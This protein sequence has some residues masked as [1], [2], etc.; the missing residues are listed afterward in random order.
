MKRLIFIILFISSPVFA[1]DISLD[2]KD[3]PVN[4]LI[5]GIVKGLLKQDYVITPEAASNEQKISLS[6]KNLDIEGVKTTLNE[7]LNS[8][9][10]SV[11]EKRGVLYIEKRSLVAPD[12]SVTVTQKPDVI[13]TPGRVPEVDSGDEPKVYFPKYRSS[14]Y[15]SLAVRAAGA[16][17]IAGQQPQ[18]FPQVVPAQMI[19]QQYQ[20][21][22]YQ[23]QQLSQVQPQQQIYKDVLVY[24][25]TAA[26]LRRVDRLLFQLDRPSVALQL[27]AAILEVT[28]STDSNRSFAA[29]LNMLG[30]RVGFSIAA[31]SASDNAVTIKAGALSAIISAVDGD[32][33]YRVLSEPSVRVVEGETAKLTVGSEVP[34]RG[35]AQTDKNGN[36]VQSIEYRTS[37]LVFEI[38]P[39]V[40]DAALRLK[41]GQQ[42]SSFIPTTTSSIDSPTLLKRE[43]STVVQ[44]DD[45]EIIAIGGLDETRET[46]SHSGV[47]F[48]PSFLRSKSEAKSKSQILLLLEVKKV[49][50]SSI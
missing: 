40:Y 19:N 7:V 36:P 26:A 27:R 6:V 1:G 20:V 33:R 29:A 45:G 38:T 34:T 35:A 39:T 23:V 22:Q 14:E 41:I 17:L 50:V 28:D 32:S 24:A 21:Q 5:Q 4:L 44:A 43:A 42:V 12:H 2:F 9:G 15:L 10:L 31:G 46:G 47:S 13:A 49:P 37:G 30:G 11:V 8:V 18:Q 16:K 3:T 48:L 25:G